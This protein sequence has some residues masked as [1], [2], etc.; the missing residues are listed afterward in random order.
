MSVFTYPW[1]LH[2]PEAVLWQSDYLTARLEAAIIGK[3][4]FIGFTASWCQQC[5]YM[6]REVWSDEAV[7]QALENYVP[8][9]VDIDAHPEI[10]GEFHVGTI[11]TLIV[12]DAK[13]DRVLKIAQEP[14]KPEAFLAWLGS[15]ACQ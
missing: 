5:Q 6:K 4:L 11:P 3:P 15:Q 9:L 13:N 14:M 12:L 7:A 8:L 1:N 2:R 10:A